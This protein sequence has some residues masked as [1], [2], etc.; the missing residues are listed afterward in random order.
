MSAT[1]IQKTYLS[2]TQARFALMIEPFPRIA[3]YWNW[4]S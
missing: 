3:A 2:P 1:S 4:K